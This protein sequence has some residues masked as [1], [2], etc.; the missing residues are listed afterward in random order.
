M[1]HYSSSHSNHSSSSSS[2]D[3]CIHFNELCVCLLKQPGLFFI[4]SYTW[5]GAVFN[6]F[7]K[8]KQIKVRK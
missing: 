3:G 2:S 5:L 7:V 8:H 4:F 6:L 1:I